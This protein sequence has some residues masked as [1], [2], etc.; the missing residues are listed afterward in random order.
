MINLEN[1]LIS[2]ISDRE[3][4]LA[5]SQERMDCHQTLNIGVI[6]EALMNRLDLWKILLQNP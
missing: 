5:L 4:L 6:Y 2:L 1:T 3:Y